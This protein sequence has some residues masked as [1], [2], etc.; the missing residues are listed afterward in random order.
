MEIV[1]RG[2]VYVDPKEVRQN[3]ED[4]NLFDRAEKIVN[5]R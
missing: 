3:M 2:T 1:G 4:E 5:N